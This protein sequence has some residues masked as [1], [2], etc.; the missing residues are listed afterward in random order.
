MKK[1]EGLDAPH[2]RPFVGPLCCPQGGQAA[3]W[4]YS[5]PTGAR[6]ARA[7]RRPDGFILGTP[8]WMGV[9][10]LATILGFAVTIAAILLVYRIAYEAAVDLAR[11]L[12]G[13]P[14]V[15][16]MV[17]IVITTL[18]IIVFIALGQWAGRMARDWINAGR[19]GAPRA[20]RS[21]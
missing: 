2:I 8:P 15:S 10:W 11:S 13:G 18:L 5:C 9:G 17:Q 7:R 6:S 14:A 20:R 16:Q 4:I 1:H 21:A 12:L 3:P 19:R